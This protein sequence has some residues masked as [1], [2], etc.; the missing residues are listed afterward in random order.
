MEYCILPEKIVGILI[1]ELSKLS[2]GFTKSIIESDKLFK[3]I[4]NKTIK[5]SMKRRN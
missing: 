2:K 1:K 5:C 3:K 4:T